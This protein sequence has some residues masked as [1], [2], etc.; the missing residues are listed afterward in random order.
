MN[1]TFL[2][3]R[4]VATIFIAIS[5][6]IS[7]NDYVIGMQDAYSLWQTAKESK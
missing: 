2:P 1:K 7:F 4:K 5:C 6:T 3:P